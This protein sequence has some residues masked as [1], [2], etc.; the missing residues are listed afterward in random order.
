M[1]VRPPH[2]QALTL[3]QQVAR[4]FANDESLRLMVPEQL[5]ITLR[6]L[7]NSYRQQLDQIVTALEEELTC[8]TPFAVSTGHLT[9][10]PNRRRPR[11]LALEIKG[12]QTLERLVDMCEQVAVQCGFAAETRCF[13][14]HITLGRFRRHLSLPDSLIQL[15]DCFFAVAQVELLESVNVHRA[16]S[17]IVEYKTLHE[18]NLSL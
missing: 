11:V 9:I 8:L 10:F 16:G 7:G 2:E 3:H 14:G 4:H 5:H 13:R 6:F 15:A 1:A 18:F 12:G 17:Q